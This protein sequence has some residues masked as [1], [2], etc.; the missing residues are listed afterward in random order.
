MRI[1]LLMGA[2]LVATCLA[3]PV[4]FSAS[5]EDAAYDRNSETVIDSSGNCVR[6]KWQDKND[7]CAPTPPP[8]P[9]PQVVKAPPPPPPPPA[10]IM[11]KEALTIYFDFNKSN[12]TAESTAKLDQVIQVIN[13]SKAITDVTIHGFTDQIGS[14]KY[15]STLASSRVESVKAYLDSKSRL[16]A[17]GDIRGIGKASPEEGCDK[18]KKR[19]EKITC[20]A[21]ERRVEIEFNA[22]K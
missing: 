22:Q 17:G 19:K 12:L 1:T 6:T 7:P 5:A 20:M 11:S 3:A 4:A 16:P 15:N 21:K 13:G 8:P 2:S 9:P 18:V 10:P 14:E